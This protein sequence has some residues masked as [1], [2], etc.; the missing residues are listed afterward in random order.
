MTSNLQYLE[1]DHWS[2]L[3]IAGKSGSGKTNTAKFLLAQLLLDRYDVYLCD[4]HATINQ[5][6]LGAT[7][8]EKVPV[9][10]DKHARMQTIRHVMRIFQRS[11]TERVPKTVLVMDEITAHFLE[12]TPEE[13]KETE[14]LFQRIANEGRKSNVRLIIC[15]QNW[16]ADYIGSRSIRSS[17]TH[18]I[19]H[20]ISDDEVKLFVPSLPTD[21]RRKITRLAPGNAY[22]F[23]SDQF[24]R[25]PYVSSDEIRSVQG[26]QKNVQGD[27]PHT[28][29]EKSDSV[30][31]VQKRAK[32]EKMIARTLELRDEGKNKE[33]TIFI[34]FGV[35][36]SGSSEKWKQASKFYDAVIAK[37]G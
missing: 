6:T 27:A 14:Q 36:K 28:H 16:R 37:R 11:L 23:P 20:Q 21:I 8:K 4:P 5:S 2:V 35:R 29:A 25:I 31:D 33:Q 32:L 15:G 1:W 34:L 17:I 24:V 18:L 3:A 7:F 22:L 26:V 13:A 10:I 19:L 12:C 9:A 30:Q